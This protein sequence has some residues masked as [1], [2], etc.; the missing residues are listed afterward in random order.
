MKLEEAKIMAALARKLAIFMAD[1]RC[2][3]QILQD[4]I[5]EH[6]IPTDWQKQLKEMQ[7][8]PE[9]RNLVAQWE[10]PLRQLEEDAEIE[11][12]LPLL[13]KISEGKP[14]N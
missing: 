7:Q 2:F 8:S 12:L 1:R 3:I 14:L 4:A 11:A 10:P 9:Y 13:Q 5:R 6:R